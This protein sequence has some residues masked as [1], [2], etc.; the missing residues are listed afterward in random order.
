MLHFQDTHDQKLLK[1]K[2]KHSQE[3][4]AFAFRCVVCSFD[5]L[6]FFSFKENRE[7]LKD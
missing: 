3:P 5:L 1:K 4:L 2:N 6:F 7:T